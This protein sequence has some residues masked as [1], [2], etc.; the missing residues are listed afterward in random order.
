MKRKSVFLFLIVGLLITLPMLAACDGEPT[1]TTTRTTP[2]P[3]YI[4]VIPVLMEDTIVGQSC[5]FL[6]TVTNE[7]E[8]DSES[9]LV[10]I[11][12]NATGATVTVGPREIAQGYVSE[13]VV[14]PDETSIG[15]T[16]TVTVEG[17]R[18]GLK[19]TDTAT[20]IVQE[21]PTT[22]GELA[23]KAIE[24]RDRFTPWLAENH[25]DLN[26]T[27]ET[28]WVGAVVYPTTQDTIRY[29]LFFSEDWEMGIRWQ[30]AEGAEDWVRIYLRM[31]T[32]E[33]APS[34]AFEISSVSAYEEPHAIAPPKAVWR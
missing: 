13:V 26:I 7:E 27:E 28:E 31:R 21:R 22:I 6:V 3:F 2:V 14:I 5:V 32:V 34:E 18:D 15:E 17:E 11:S 23:L 25:P 30:A 33:L 19:E 29:Y 12:A 20:L 9:G 1:D 16:L 10:Y 8:V 4:D 24:L